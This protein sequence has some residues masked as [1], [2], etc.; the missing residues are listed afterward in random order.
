M[1]LCTL[2]LVPVFICFAFGCVLLGQPAS[3][4]RGLWVVRTSIRSPEAIDKLVE[5]AA[6]SGFNTLLVQVRGRGD[7]LYVSRLEPRSEL[8]KDQPDSFDP[9][10]YLLEKAKARNLRV[11]AWVNTLLVHVANGNNVPS[12]H[13]LARHPEWAMT[14]R[15]L[16]S[17]VYAGKARYPQ[18]LA[19][20]AG[21][22]KKRPDEIEGF[23][24][25]PAAAARPAVSGAGLY[26]SPFTLPGRRPASRLSAIPE[27]GLRF[28]SDS[29]DSFREEIDKNL[30]PAARKR[31]SKAFLKN[32]LCY[33]AQYPNQW[34]AFRRRQ[35][36]KLLEQ[37]Q[38]A[39][40]AQRP[41][42]ILTAAVKGDSQVAFDNKFQD[43]TEWMEQR[44]LDGVCPMAYTTDTAVFK[45][46]VA[47]A[48]GF[49]FGAQVWAGIGAWHIP[50]E[51]TLE[52]IS[53]ARKIRAD[54]FLL[55]C[56]GTLSEDKPVLP[57]P[58]LERLKAFLRE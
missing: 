20:I 26:G 55:F 37:L 28:R 31:M 18:S 12:G 9:L 54:G 46:Q 22:I 23:Y 24:L 45:N 48:R 17:L 40:K 41:G 42:I 16:A 57:D 58:A 39:A 27:P 2:R 34:D 52:K 19:D 11:H 49:S 56:Y 38:K 35:V 1:N 51:S 4:V 10:G 47:I 13:V 3:E 6:D 5:Q 50:I 53:I 44:L 21:I 25:D 7:A 36:T 8:V 29:L 15:G 14:P 43:W 32:R 30:K 33:T